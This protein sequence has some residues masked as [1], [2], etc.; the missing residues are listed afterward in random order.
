MSVLKRE[1]KETKHSVLQRQSPCAFCLYVLFVSR[2]LY[3]SPFFR[4]PAFSS[5]FGGLWPRFCVQYIIPPSET[6]RI[7]ANE[8]LMMNV[9][10]L[11]ASPEWKEVM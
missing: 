10:V 8:L 3:L 7:I 9:M 4:Q 5:L 2:S 6:A 1:L 11:C